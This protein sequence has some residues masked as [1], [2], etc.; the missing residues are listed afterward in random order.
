[1][2]ADP[3]DLLTL[4]HASP[5][6]VAEHDKEAW[7]GLFSRYH[8]VEDP[9]GGRPVLGGLY[10][11]R[12]RRRG[13]DPLARFW[14]TFI[15]P[16][17]IRFHVQRDDIVDGLTVVRDVTIETRLGRGVV[18]HAPMHLLYEATL[19]E[20]EPRIRRIAAHWEVAPMFAKVAGVSPAKL[21]VGT[22]MATRMLRNLGLGGS[23]AF[24]AAVRS[25]GEPGKTAVRRLVEAATR[26]DSDALDTLGGRVVGDITKIIAA[27]D[28]VTA[29]CTVDGSPALL[30]CYLD[31]SSL[32]VVR[33]DVY[34]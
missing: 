25:V 4:A 23:V 1:M 6:A 21:A 18:A 20:G 26:G 30:C 12:R 29:S 10:D 14:D 7:L 8:V 28:T 17:D 19:D 32:R 31:R 16:N 24:G 34:A 9:V 2:L 33:A 22:S 15:A 27:G 13:R 5:A 11:P 3:A